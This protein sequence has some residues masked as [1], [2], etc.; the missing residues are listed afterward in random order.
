MKRE[1]KKSIRVKYSSNLSNLWHKRS[2]ST[3]VTSRSCLKL[4]EG[5][6]RSFQSHTWK[7]LGRSLQCHMRRSRSL[8]QHA[9]ILKYIKVTQATIPWLCVCGG[10]GA[11]SKVISR[12]Y[13]K[14]VL[15]V[16]QSHY[17][18]TSGTF[19]NIIAR[20][21]NNIPGHNWKV[22]CSIAWKF[23]W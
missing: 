12:S 15:K 11:W 5:H 20:S 16:I 10:T 6:P 3:A 21:Y 9:N 19:D 22:Q 2:W 23:H 8:L 14:N 7:F 1:K 17:K 13:L 4:K 18:A